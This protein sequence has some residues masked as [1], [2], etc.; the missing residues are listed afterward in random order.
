MIK[1]IKDKIKNDELIKGSLILFIMI[2]IYNFLNYI[3]HFS[4]ARL[5]GPA[6]YG[7]LAVLFSFIYIFSIPSESIQNFI[8]DYTSKHKLKEECWKIKS[9]LIK[10]IK[11]GFWFSFILYLIFLLL[12]Y[13]ISDFI[14]IDF[15]LLAFTG[16]LIF[17]SMLVP[18]VRGALQG[19]KRFLNLGWNMIIESLIKVVLSIDL[20]L[21]SW[22]VFG[23]IFA[24]ILGLLIAFILGILSLSKIMK[25][26]KENLKSDGIYQSFFPYF[27]IML[28]VTLIYSLD[29]IFARRFFSEE[30]SGIYAVASMLGKMIF[31]GTFAIGKAMLPLTLEKHSNG[32]KTGFLLKKSLKIIVLI[33]AIALLLY[34]FLPEFIISLLFGKKYILASGIIFWIGLGLTFLSLSNIILLYLVSLKQIKRPYLFLFFV[35]LEIIFFY[36]FH[37]SLIEFSIS[38]LVANLILLGSLILIL[39]RKIINPLVIKT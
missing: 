9:I 5:L 33:S 34:W 20:V 11:K 27:F 17:L 14:K 26:K 12:A 10:S 36:L 7:V 3:F 25:E 35:F 4:M 28:S 13:F 31:F 2:N 19:Q 18:I 6:E 38:F 22:K 8:A 15:M 21:L 1:N 16:L 24:V 29:T 30:L 23:A 32:E 39:K 37:S